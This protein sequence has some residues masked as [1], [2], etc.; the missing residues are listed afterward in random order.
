MGKVFVMRIRYHIFFFDITIAGC[1][2][3]Y[4]IVVV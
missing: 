4:L 3:P 1:L 2:V